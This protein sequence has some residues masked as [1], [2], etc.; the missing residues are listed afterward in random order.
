MAQSHV[1]V[2]DD[3]EAI[4]A[5]MRAVLSTTYAVSTARNGREGLDLCK[6][7][8]PDLV[9]LDLSMPEMDV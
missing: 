7:L 6:R 9:L 8:V 1:L 3:S 4:L 5:F 2:V